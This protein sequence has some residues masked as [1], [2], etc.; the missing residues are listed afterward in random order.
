MAE[1][2]I[3]WGLVPGYH[4]YEAL[5]D[6]NFMLE[7]EDKH[8]LAMSEYNQF[9]FHGHEM[10]H[11]FTYMIPIESYNDPERIDGRIWFFGTGRHDCIGVGGSD[12]VRS[13]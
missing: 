12:C 2:G 9:M 7:E 4:D 13:D 11:Q 6:D 8:N 3:P 5:D 10:Y 1:N